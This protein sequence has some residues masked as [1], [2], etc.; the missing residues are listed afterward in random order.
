MQ[1]RLPDVEDGLLSQMIGGDLSL[2]IHVV[3]SGC[4][5]RT[6]SASTD[7][8]SGR[9]EEGRFILQLN[10]PLSLG[11]H[12]LSADGANTASA[13]SHPGIPRARKSVN[14]CP[15]CEAEW[16]PSACLRSASY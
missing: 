2:R 13:A 1:G 5:A 9:T 3:A 4:K 12:D 11:R 16:V 14:P 7:V 10:D 6:I 15:R 8:K